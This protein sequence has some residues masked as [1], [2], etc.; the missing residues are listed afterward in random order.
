MS[1]MTDEEKSQFIVLLRS[2]KPVAV[3][4]RNAYADALK[5]ALQE[6][7]DN[8]HKAM[9]LADISTKSLMEEDADIDIRTMSDDTFTR[10]CLSNDWNF[11]QIDE[12]EQELTKSGEK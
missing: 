4:V 7:P 2:M 10:L 1:R 11:G 6:Y 3:E 9:E 12:L 8:Q 5:M